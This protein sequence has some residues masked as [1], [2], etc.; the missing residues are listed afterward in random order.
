M[1]SRVILSA[2]GERRVNPVAAA[3]D[4]TLYLGG[5]E[6]LGAAFVVDGR[7][8]RGA[9]GLAGEIAHLPVP[10]AA[11]VPCWCGS[12][13]CLEAVVGRA[14][15][16]RD[17]RLLADSDRARCWRRSWPER[18]DP[19]RRD[20]TEAADGGDL[21]ARALLERNG[22]FLGTTLATLVSVFNPDLVILG[23]GLQR[24]SAFLLDAIREAIHSRARPASP[25]ACASS[26]RPWTYR[27]GASSA[28]SSSPLTASSLQTS[29]RAGCAEVPPM[30]HGTNPPDAGLCL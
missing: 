23:G 21:A 5:G 8:Y 28:P 30:A 15:L 10:D 27:P 9:R 17:G 24:A 22:T 25:R 14:A 6:E 26:P 4:Q 19:A 16:V 29:S 7:V 3:S 11:D 20:I 1:E 2:I 13:R 12:R 18:A